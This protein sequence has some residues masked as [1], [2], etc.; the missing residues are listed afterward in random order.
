MR[1]KCIGLA[2]LEDVL[3]ERCQNGL[4][5]EVE[6]QRFHAPDQAAL[7]VADRR[8]MPSRQALVPP[9]ARPFLQFMYVSRHSPHLMRRLCLSFAAKARTISAHCAEIKRVNLRSRAGFAYPRFILETRCAIFETE[10]AFCREVAMRQ[11]IKCFII[12]FTSSFRRTP[13]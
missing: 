12:V 2:G 4:G 8:E 6:P 10:C 7:P 13:D 11:L 1:G 9:E 3:R 5:A